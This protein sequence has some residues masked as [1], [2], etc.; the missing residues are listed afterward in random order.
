MRFFRILRDPTT[1]YLFACLM[2]KHVEEMRKYAI[3]VMSRTQGAKRN[4]EPVY[5]AYPLKRL[6]H[7]L[8]FEDMD[9]ARAACKHYNITVKQMKMSKAETEQEG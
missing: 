8:C 7:I 2:F 5:D 4:G 1:P 9:E 3:K 6:A